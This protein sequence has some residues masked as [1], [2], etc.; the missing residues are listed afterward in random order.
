M[1][2]MLFNYMDCNHVMQ[3]S[4]GCLSLALNMRTPAPE[5][6]KSAKKTKEEKVMREKVFRSLSLWAVVAVF[7][8]STSA[9]ALAGPFILSGTDSDDHGFVFAGANQDGW[10][11]MQKA[12][13]NL[14]PS[15]TNGNKVVTILGSTSNAGTAA[16]SAFNL[17]NLV[18][19]GWTVQTISTANFAT[20]FGAGGGLANSGILMMDSGLN[21]SGGIDGSAF[22][23]FASAINTFVGNGGGL[24]S[25]GNGYDWVTALVPSLT[26]TDVGGG[27]V[28]TALSLTAAGNA[29]FPGLTNGDLSTGPWHNYFTNVGTLPVLATAPLSGVTRNV[30]IGSSSG[31]ITNPG[32]VPEPSTLLLLG[33][34]LIGIAARRRAK[35]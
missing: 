7:S 32:G 21:T 8:I 34:G 22:V 12:L 31:S 18:G 30:I 27:G 33:A 11:F 13:E 2:S 1:P 23:P 9:V 6:S 19:S 35:A 29:A 15:V 16:N 28:G 3:E 4:Q 14:A 10:L 24:F 17:S 25:Q 20:F 5:H 26:V